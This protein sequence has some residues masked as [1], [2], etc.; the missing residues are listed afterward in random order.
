MK[1]VLWILVLIAVVG[2]IPG[3]VSIGRWVADKAK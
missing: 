3:Y 2:A 1:M